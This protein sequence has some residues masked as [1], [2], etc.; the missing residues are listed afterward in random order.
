VLHVSFWVPLLFSLF[1]IAHGLIHLLWVIPLPAD[2]SFPFTLQRSPW[3][4]TRE[5]D[6][7]LLAA[8]IALVG[9][10]VAEFAL[11]GLGVMGVPLLAQGWRVLAIVG[12]LDSLLVTVLFWDRQLWPGPILDIAIVIAAVLGWPRP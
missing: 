10:A 1:L 4:K 12:A 2:P 3:F 6:R 5:D 9:L 11:A 8:G 7:A